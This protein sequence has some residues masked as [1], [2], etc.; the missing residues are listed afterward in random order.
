MQKTIVFLLASLPVLAAAAIP[1]SITY[2][3]ENYTTVFALV[4]PEG[5][6]CHVKSDSSWFGEQDFEVPFK[7]KA[8]ANYYYTFDCKLP[9][10]EMWH[11]RLEPKANHTTIV[12][13]GVDGPKTGG[14]TTPAPTGGKKK[15]MAKADFQ[16]L[17]EEIEKASFEDDQLS[18]VEMASKLNYF[19]SQ[20][21]GQLVD[22]ITFEDG[23]VETVAY[24]AKRIVDLKKSHSILAHFTFSEGKNKAK[25]LLMRAASN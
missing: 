12:K 14:S 6:Q 15:A 19:T 4:A 25:K 17:L 23:K 16:K 3:M 11:K 13:V 9:S 18:V 7:F 20:Q 1:H 5:A 2:K 8:Q 24:T 21:V 10:G 22:A